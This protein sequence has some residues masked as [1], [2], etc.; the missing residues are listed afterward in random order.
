MEIWKDVPGYEDSYQISQSGKVRA[1]YRAIECKN[2][3]VVTKSEGALRERINERGYL[4]VTLSKNNTRKSCKVHRLVAIAF[5]P[6]PFNYPEVNH[7]DG[8]KTNNSHDNLEWCTRQQN[9]DHA[10]RTLKVKTS[11]SGGKNPRSKA[12]L[13]T[14][15][16]QIYETI[17]DAAISINMKPATLQAKLSGKN[18]NDTFLKFN[19]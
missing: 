11:H 10:Y 14:L 16:G 7:K 8:N 2:R 13:N 17:N 4:K 1:K 9:I 5:I 18:P 15:S 3:V 19:N 6:N 12:V